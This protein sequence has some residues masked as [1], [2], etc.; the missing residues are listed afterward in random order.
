MKE[1]TETTAALNPFNFYLPRARSEFIETML[2]TSS[3]GTEFQ[4]IFFSEC[5]RISVAVFYLKSYLLES[6][7]KICEKMRIVFNLY[8]C[9]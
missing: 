5:S 4:K 3:P 6:I 2:T 1:K 8:V 7:G 9:M